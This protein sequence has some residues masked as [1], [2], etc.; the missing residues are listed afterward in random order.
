MPMRQRAK[1][2]GIFEPTE[3]DLLARVFHYLKYDGQTEDQPQA[4][5]SR[6][7]PTSWQASSMKTSLFSLSRLPLG[8]Q[9]LCSRSPLPSY[10][11]RR[12]WIRANRRSVLATQKMAGQS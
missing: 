1:D 11:R 4:L 7:S 8:R 10:R 3:L 9:E 2:A 6:I 12:L 5:A